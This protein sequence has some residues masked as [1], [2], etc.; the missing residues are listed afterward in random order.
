M[1]PIPAPVYDNGGTF[2][3]GE[4]NDRLIW[5]TLIIAGRAGGDVGYSYCVFWGVW[6][7]GT[8]WNNNHHNVLPPEEHPR[9]PPPPGIPVH[10]PMVPLDPTPFPPHHTKNP[11][12]GQDYY[13]VWSIPQFLIEQ[14]AHARN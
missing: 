9:F 8:W 13:Q 4:N 6:A 3:L 11:V 14:A 12:T 7:I 1:Q 10:P 2:G 5:G